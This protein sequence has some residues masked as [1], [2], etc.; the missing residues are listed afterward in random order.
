MMGQE[1][2]SSQSAAH[3][4]GISYRQLDH[5]AR[6]GLLPPSLSPAE[7]GIGRRRRYSFLDVVA[8]CTVAELRRA[9]VSLQ[10]LRRVVAELRRLGAGV[11]LA[12]ARLVVDG[13]DVLLADGDTALSIL[14]KPGQGVLRMFVD[15]GDVVRQLHEAVAA[16]PATK[17]RPIAG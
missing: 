5:W 3:L 10:A 17:A 12:E 2:F 13:D 8:L 4:A 6:S 7:P 9:G 14:R 15:L 11:A 16:T 1:A